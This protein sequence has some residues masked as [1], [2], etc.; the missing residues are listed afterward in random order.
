MTKACFFFLR[1]S[2]K[3]SEPRWLTPEGL[4]SQDCS[5]GGGACGLQKQKT[6]TLIYL[7]LTRKTH[8]TPS[9]WNCWES[10]GIC[11]LE[12]RRSLVHELHDL[13]FTSE[14][15]QR[16]LLLALHKVFQAR[17]AGDLEAISHPLVHGG[18]HCCQHA[19]TLEK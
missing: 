18:I 13:V 16:V 19:R 2:R 10:S 12:L 11:D 17:E 6:I 9:Q 1:A 5:G 4:S 8:T 14:L 7:C 3:S 15:W